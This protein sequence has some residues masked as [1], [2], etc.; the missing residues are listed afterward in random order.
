M[1][2]F[3]V[4][5]ENIR[6]CDYKNE[7]YSVRDDGAVMR[8]PK[9]LLQPRPLDNKWTYGKFD[10]TSGYLLIG[11][12]RVHRIV[13]TAFHGEPVGDRNIVDHEDT[14][15]HNNR[16]E[17]LHW[18]TRLEN[19]LNNPITVAKIELICGSVEAFIANPL[20]L[21]NHEKENPNFKWMRKVTPQEA[22]AS[23]EKW[24]EWSKKPVALRAGK[25]GVVG[26]WLY[27]TTKEDSSN[28]FYGFQR[29]ICQVVDRTSESRFPLA[30]L[31]TVEGEDVLQKYRTALV[32]GKDFLIS[33]Y[34]KTVCREVVY[35]EKE[36]KLRVLSERIDGQ[37]TP[38]YIFEIWA[39]NGIIY[40]KI[41][42]S[43]GKMRQKGIEEAMHDLSKY[44]RQEWKYTRN[45]P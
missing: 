44:N 30:P 10:E 2:S 18:V 6:E 16:P 41:V 25:G 3:S 27:K 20:L 5:S 12:E 34:Y 39:D 7:H 15:R 35:F 17:N 26:E 19:V 38:F 40:H 29:W 23:Y 36:D 45:K 24:L 11:Q 13:C 22:K 43:Y 33:T 42:G 37:R 21:Q 1:E 8:H 32:A 9:S 4:Q 14:N 31:S 28:Q